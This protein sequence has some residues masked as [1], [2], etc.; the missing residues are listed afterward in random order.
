MAHIGQTFAT[1]E[2]ALPLTSTQGAL[3]QVA[4]LSYQ[5]NTREGGHSHIKSFEAHRVR[6]LPSFCWSGNKQES[7][8]SA[9]R[10]VR[11]EQGGPWGGA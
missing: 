10:C 2:M 11:K 9:Q 1:N 3:R 7:S 6:S 4:S 8:V 5:G